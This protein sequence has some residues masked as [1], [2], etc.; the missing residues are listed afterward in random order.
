MKKP[1]TAVAA[2]DDAE[3]LEKEDWHDLLSSR[4]WDRLRAAFEAQWG[5]GS[6]V[7]IFE[8]LAQRPTAE[9]ADEVKRVLQVRV[10]LRQFLNYPQHRLHELSRMAAT[11]EAANAKPWTRESR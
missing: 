10:A 4:G 1:K 7:T 6:V 2:Q 3:V 8:G 5:D 9:V 11:Q